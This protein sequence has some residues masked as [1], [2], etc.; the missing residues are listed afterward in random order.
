M[1]SLTIEGDDT[2]NLCTS[3]IGKDTRSIAAYANNTKTFFGNPAWRINVC[4]LFFTRNDIQRIYDQNK[5]SRKETL[6]LAFMMSAGAAFL[7]EMMHLTSI[8]QDRTH[9]VDSM[10]DGAAGKR[11]YGPKDVAKAAR[12]ASRENDFSLQAY[13]A[14]TYAVFAQ[15][16]IAVLL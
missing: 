10:F 7:H 14:D 12:I 4:D 13:N 2:E 6:S 1:H 16:T 11:I 9:I 8:T 5:D 3:K 15:G